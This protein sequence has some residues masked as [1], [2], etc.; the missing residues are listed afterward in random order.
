MAAEEDEDTLI[1]DLISGKPGPA[2]VPDDEANTPGT[3]T[4]DG[5]EVSSV[6]V[7][8]V[9]I[10]KYGNKWQVPGGNAEDFDDLYAGDIYK[11]P[12][13]MSDVFHVQMIRLD[14]VHEYQLRGFVLILQE[15][16]GIPPE[17][18]KDMGHPLDRYHR[19]GD[20][21]MVKI[22]HIINKR[23][24]QKK[25]DETR[26]RLLELEPTPEMLKRAGLDGLLVEHKIGFTGADPATR[27]LLRADESGKGRI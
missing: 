20:A 3:I 25:E 22:P 24:Q 8:G 6:E 15:E 10:D 21:V 23:L 14:Q 4:N 19:V 2:A 18:I 16:L 26:R 7:G 13:E 1:G 9:I 5:L 12:K 17:M 27:G 11:I